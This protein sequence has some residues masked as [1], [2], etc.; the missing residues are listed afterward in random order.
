MKINVYSLITVIV[1]SFLLSY[2]YSLDASN[3]DNISHKPLITE[4]FTLK[5]PIRLY[6][7]S[8]EKVLIAKI[9]YVWH[10]SINKDPKSPQNIFD[11]KLFQINDEHM[12]IYRV[13]QSI[14]HYD[15][16]TVNSSKY[17]MTIKLENIDLLCNDHYWLC[18]LGEFKREYKKKLKTLVMDTPKDVTDV[19]MESEARNHC[20]V[21]SVGVIRSMN[22]LGYLCFDEREDL[23][24]FLDL[25]SERIL[26]RYKTDY[27]G[28][29]RLINQV[30][31]INT[32]TFNYLSFIYLFLELS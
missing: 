15:E 13:D 21:F 12:I 2:S 32:Y 5:T 10:S 30:L 16:Q 4:K 26:K 19:I 11:Y 14:S 28:Q 18:T 7:T 29:L 8:K 9:R 24:F 31:N 27:E 25:I 23:V 22:D 1:L 20:A 3:K 17:L 6:N